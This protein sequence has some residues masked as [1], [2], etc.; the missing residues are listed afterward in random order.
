MTCLIDSLFSCK[1]CI[2]K[3]L[4]SEIS[5]FVNSKILEAIKNGDSSISFS[6]GENGCWFFN[7]EMLIKTKIACTILGFFVMTSTN[8]D[9]EEIIIFL[10]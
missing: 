10:Q 6:C 2:C 3:S 8:G 1:N 5:D 9:K 7:H 4:N